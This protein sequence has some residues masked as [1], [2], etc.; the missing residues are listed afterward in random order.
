MKL[1]VRDSQYGRHE[2]IRAFLKPET[3]VIAALLAAVDLEWTIRRVIDAAAA[4]RTEVIGDKNISG[5]DGYAKAW[6][7]VIAGPKAKTLENIVGNWGDLVENYQIRHDIVH[8]RKGSTGLRYVT[9][10]VESFLAASKA[11]ADFG[12]DYGANPFQFRRTPS[13]L[14]GPTKRKKGAHQDSGH[15]VRQDSTSD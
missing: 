14:T 15:P 5:L 10:R 2:H 11:I 7:R 4:G 8:G 12:I 6:N 9:I 13:I 3:T 1:L